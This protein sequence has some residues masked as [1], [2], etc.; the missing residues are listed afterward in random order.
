MATSYALQIPA[1]EDYDLKLSRI[2]AASHAN[3]AVIDSSYSDNVQS[4]TYAYGAGDAADVFTVVVRRSYNAKSN[5]TNCSI[6]VSALV[7]QTVS[8]TG[9]VTYL[10]V[11]AL[12]A[13]NYSGEH[14]PDMVSMIILAQVSSSIF[15]Q[16]LS[17]V[18]GNPTAKVME[19][20]DHA[21]TGKLFG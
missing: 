1:V 5:M 21:I 8:E 17:G 20:L 19:Q 18:N 6:R 3:F 4:T 14:V 2:A 12:Q 9:E 16:E 13:W 10:P 15:Y 11:E 7:K